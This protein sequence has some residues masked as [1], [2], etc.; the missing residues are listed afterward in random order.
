[1]YIRTYTYVYIYIYIYIHDTCI[2]RTEQQTQGEGL[3]GDM[4][5]IIMITIIQIIMI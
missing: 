3:G 5:L 1:M 4:L 2:E